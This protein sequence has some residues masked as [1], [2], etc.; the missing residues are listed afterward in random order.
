[1]LPVSTK[2]PVE[3]TPEHYQGADG[4]PVYLIEVPSDLRKTQLNSLVRE[5]AGE[6]ISID[7][8]LEMMRRCIADL[9]PEN[10]RDTLIDSVDQYECQL[11]EL[12]DKSR[13]TVDA[14]LLRDIEHIEEG[15]KAHHPDY[16]N[17][18]NRRTTYAEVLPIIATQLFLIGRKGESPLPRQFGRLKDGETEKLPPRDKLAIGYFA[19]NL[20][21]LSEEQ[22]KN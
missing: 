15:L 18:L 12:A 6:L 8:L 7:E 5:H 20:T 16:R 22:R 11:K 3:F 9:F 19:Y 10:E 21:V 14:A 13:E 4:A 2:Q 1:M 17:A